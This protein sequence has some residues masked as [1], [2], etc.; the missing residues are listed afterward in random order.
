MR[1]ET[2]MAV[3]GAPVAWALLREDGSSA[4]FLHRFFAAGAWRERSARG[5]LRLALGSLA[6]P[7]VMP[8]LLLACTVRLG[9]AVK[10]SFGRG[11]ARQTLGQVELLLRAC[12]PPPWYYIFELHEEVNRRRA[13][14]YLYRFET[15]ACL[16]HFLRTYLTRP[17]TLEALSNKILF[18]ERCRENGVPAIPVIGLARGGRYEA[19]DAEGLGLP[20]RSL[21]LK[22]LRGS[23]GGGAERW[24]YGGGSYRAADGRVLG[25]ARM[26]EH[27]ERLSQD[28][29]YLVRPWLE[30]HPDLSDLCCGVLSTVRVLTIRNESGGFEATHAV[31]K[32]ARHPQASVDNASRGG[33]ASKVDLATG[34]LGRA[35]NKG[36][37]RDSGWW[38]RHP[39][40]GATI[41]GR[42]LPAWERVLA[43]ALKAH[44]AF[45]D[46]VVVGWDIA[47]LES[48][49]ALVEG[50]KGPGLELMQRAQQEPLGSGRFGELVAFHLR[51]A[52]EERERRRIPLEP[53]G[54]SA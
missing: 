54:R 18:A 48:G 10:K 15:K 3:S 51:R 53:P 35:T 44:E 52:L 24:Q 27:L 11:Y 50:N 4:R 30:N 17:E 5:R 37:G 7:L 47:L 21:F 22:P 9:P 19:L 38:D 46:Q 34:E 26:I 28:C 31:F 40:T 12:I 14:E 49:P 6:W 1:S 8:P 2:L 41:T 29:P 16:F 39:S 32:M 45:P 13:L 43:T 25:P 23:G 36:Y 20:R 33:I 42:K